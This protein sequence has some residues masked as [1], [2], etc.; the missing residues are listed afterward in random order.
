M[1]SENLCE[2]LSFAL[3]FI[4]EHDEVKA[5]CLTEIQNVCMSKGQIDISS[6]NIKRLVYLEAC[7]KETLRLRTF[8]NELKLHNRKGHVLK[9]SKD[10]QFELG[11]ELALAKILQLME[12]II[13]A[14]ITP[15]F[16][17][18]QVTT[19]KQNNICLPV[20]AHLLYV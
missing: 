7:I 9:R 6:E 2:A 15:S 11:S 3:S 19:M 8:S 14:L 18:L 16:F 1:H 17:M 20:Y 5:K 10:R 12:K 4:T 13:I